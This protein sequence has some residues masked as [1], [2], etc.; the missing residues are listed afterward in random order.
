MRKISILLVGLCFVFCGENPVDNNDNLIWGT[1]SDIDGNVY[2]TIKIGNQEWMAENL[3][4]TKYNDGVAIPHVT[5]NAAWSSLT[6]PGCCYYNNA[7]HADT[8]KKWGA[9]YNWYVV[10]PTNSN[11]IAPAGWHVPKDSE[12]TV[13][14]KYLVLNGY[15]W[16]GTTDTSDTV[17]NKIAKA[18]ASKS[19]WYEYNGEGAPGNNPSSNNRSGFSALPGGSRYDDGNFYYQSSHGACWSAT[20]NDAYHAYYRTLIY[21]NESLNRRYYTKSCGFSVRLLRD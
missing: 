14:E 5:D 12:W 8:I 17:Y 1:M 9:L 7:T 6:T 19:D 11:K 18:M 13:L 20:E 3:R 15:N 2:K 16:D 21:T 10:A 4:V